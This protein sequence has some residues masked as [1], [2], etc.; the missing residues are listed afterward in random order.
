MHLI[1]N[2]TTMCLCSAGTMVVNYVLPLEVVSPRWRT[3]CGCI[4]FWACG[5]MTLAPLAYFIR[6]WRY[7]TGV[8]ALGGVPLLFT[9]RYGGSLYD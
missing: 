1:C 7:L 9:W 3:F 8:C 2:I 5:V 4:G 6:N